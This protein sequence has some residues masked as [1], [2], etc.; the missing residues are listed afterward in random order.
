VDHSNLLT[1]HFNQQELSKNLSSSF[2]YYKTRNYRKN[3]LVQNT[4]FYKI[5]MQHQNYKMQNM[6]IYEMLRSISQLWTSRALGIRI[7]FMP[8]VTARASRKS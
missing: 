3:N 4:F 2:S 6:N 8:K 5:L 7:M 1:T